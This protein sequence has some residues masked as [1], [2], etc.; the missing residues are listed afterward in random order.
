MIEKGIA[1]K[2][3]TQSHSTHNFIREIKKHLS[4]VIALIFFWRIN[5][6]SKATI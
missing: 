4:V 2:Q 5:T 1:D 6:D 3:H